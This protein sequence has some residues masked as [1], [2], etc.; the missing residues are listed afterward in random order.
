MLVL[1][2]RA[3]PADRETLLVEGILQELDCSRANPVQRQQVL[4]SMARKLGKA[5]H[6]DRSE[7]S[8]RG[9]ADLRQR[10]V[11]GEGTLPALDAERKPVGGRRLL[12]TCDHEELPIAGR[13]AV[14]RSGIW[15]TA[16][17]EPS[18]VP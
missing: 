8:G 2:I 15:V 9:C 17:K 10:V 11:H 3:I 14:P 5:R 12:P 13:P 1:S 7:R 6:P 16:Q 18:S 4:W